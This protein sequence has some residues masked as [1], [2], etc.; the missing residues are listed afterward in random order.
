MSF[1]TSAHSFS[2]SFLPSRMR[3]PVSASHRITP[4]ENTSARA[5]TFQPRP[6]SGDMYET[7]PLTTPAWVSYIESDAF[8]MPK[9]S[10]LTWPSNVTNT[11]CG[12]T[13]RCTM[14]SGEPSKSVSLWA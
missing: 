13:S 14:L 7:L 9:S 12:L 2:C 10:S 4:A 1:D 8:A 3:L 5:S 6:C 11:F